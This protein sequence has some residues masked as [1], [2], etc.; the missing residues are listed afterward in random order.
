MTRE[1]QVR[2][3]Q[4]LLTAPDQVWHAVA[5]SEGN[6]G[7]LYPMEIEPRIGGNV[8]RGGGTVVEWEPPHRFA[9]RVTRDGGFSNTLSYHIEPREDGTSHLRMGI[10]WVHEGVVDDGWDTRADAAEKHVDFYQHSLAQYLTHFAGRSAACVKADRPRPT[11]DPAEF[12]ALR[13]RLGVPDGTAVG[14]RLALDQPGEDG[15]PVD[16]VVDYL[17]R[18]FLG[19]R[20]P[21]ALY[22][23]FDGS[24][25]NWPIWVGHHL[26]AKDADPER[27]TRAWTG[28]LN[29]R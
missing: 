24:S 1:F 28:W 17:T 19:L 7:W 4:R 23:F 13:H 29:D 25:W 16:V 12:A 18:D 9:A 22:R 10:H 6:L 26:F 14:D 27:A 11:A 3:E 20:G 8:S 2:R 21:D 15:G 5:T